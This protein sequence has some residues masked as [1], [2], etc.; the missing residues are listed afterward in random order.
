MLG[1]GP[2]LPEAKSFVNELGIGSQVTF[3]GAVGNQEVLG[4]LRR[5][6]VYVQHSVTA[7]NGDME[8]WPVAL[9]EAASCG[10]PVVSTRHGGITSQVLHDQSGFLVD[11][12]EEE[13]MSHHMALLAKDPSLRREMGARGRHHMVANFDSQRQIRKLEEVVLNVVNKKRNI[14][15]T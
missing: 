11:E 7:P 8:G 14:Q 4:A 5:A 9:A 6:S 2:L 15:N 3:R 12:R 1:D 13:E 10:L